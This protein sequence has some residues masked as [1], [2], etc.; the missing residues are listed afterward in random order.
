M[1]EGF[2]SLVAAAA[3]INTASPFRKSLSVEA[4]R[5]LIRLAD[6]RVH[7]HRPHPYLVQHR[8]HGWCANSRIWCCRIRWGHA[9]TFAAA[10]KRAAIICAMGTG[11]LRNWVSGFTRTTTFFLV[12]R[13]EM[14]NVPAEASTEKPCRK[15]AERSRHYL[16]GSEASSIRALCAASAEL[17]ANLNFTEGAGGRIVEFHR[18]RSVP[19]QDCGLRHCDI[20]ILCPRRRHGSDHHN[21]SRSVYLLDQAA[22]SMPLPLLLIMGFLLVKVGLLHAYNCGGYEASGLITWF[23]ADKYSISNLQIA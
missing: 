19:T 12:P 23:P 9:A 15:N 14:V 17:V 13:S 20:H 8:R 5:R 4:G 1:A 18:S 21:S 22:N 16:I 11:S 10:F 3:T 2:A 7:P 6:L